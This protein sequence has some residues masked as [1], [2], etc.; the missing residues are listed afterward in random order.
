[1]TSRHL[2]GP[3]PAIREQWSE[4][5]RSKAPPALELSV[6]HGLSERSSLIAGDAAWPRREEC[7]IPKGEAVHQRPRRSTNW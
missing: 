6:L 3:T 7:R 2:R 5:S 4:K 1:M